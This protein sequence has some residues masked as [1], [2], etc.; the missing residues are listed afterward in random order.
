M[1]GEFNSS[2]ERGNVLL[3]A[4]FVSRISGVIARRVERNVMLIHYI[5]RGTR[6]HPLIS[7]KNVVGFWNEYRARR[8]DLPRYV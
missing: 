8:L 6:E 7:F 4:F 3:R 1:E 2:R 5:G